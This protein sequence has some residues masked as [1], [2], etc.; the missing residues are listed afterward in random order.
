VY[1]V[2]RGAIDGGV[3]E[4]THE[5]LHRDLGATS[6]VDLTVPPPKTGFYYIVS[7]RTVCGEGPLG[8]TSA[9]SPRPNPSPCPP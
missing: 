5:C 2:Y 4:F 3:W 8:S 1:D 9:G 7:S 6:A